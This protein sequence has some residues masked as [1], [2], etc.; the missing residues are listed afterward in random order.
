MISRE[1]TNC[2]TITVYLAFPEI[3]PVRG[4]KYFNNEGQ[5]ISRKSDQT[6]RR[7]DIDRLFGI[8]PDQSLYYPFEVI[9]QVPF[10]RFTA[11][12]QRRKELNF[13]LGF[14]AT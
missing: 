12:T 10:I 8:S 1:I 7:C 3:Y 5:D 9:S 11:K 13:K 2:D 6:I 14:S 4:E